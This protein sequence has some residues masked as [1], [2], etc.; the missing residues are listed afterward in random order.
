MPFSRFLVSVLEPSFLLTSLDF[1]GRMSNT[2]PGPRLAPEIKVP[3]L[4]PL[5]SVDL[6]DA[7]LSSKKSWRNEG[8]GEGME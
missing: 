6:Q 8:S 4:S 2:P 1:H 3:P 7:L 5:L